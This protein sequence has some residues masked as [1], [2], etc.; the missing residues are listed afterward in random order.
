[1]PQATRIHTRNRA[2]VLI[3]F[4][5]SCV[6]RAVIAPAAVPSREDANLRENCRAATASLR[7]MTAL[8]ASV[9]DLIQ[10]D[11]LHLAACAAVDRLKPAWREQVE[12]ASRMPAHS[13]SGLY[14]KASLLDSLIERDDQNTALGGAALSVAASLAADVLHQRWTAGP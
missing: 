3:H 2:S 9:A 11:P 14:E 1:M 13:A 4:G 8:S 10:D 12:Q 6:P 7:A 5:G